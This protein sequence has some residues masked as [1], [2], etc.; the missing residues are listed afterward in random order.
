VTSSITAFGLETKCKEANEHQSQ[1]AK[2]FNGF[3]GKMLCLPR[4][5]NVP[6]SIE[7]MPFLLGLSENNVRGLLFF[8][9]ARNAG[10]VHGFHRNTLPKGGNSTPLFTTF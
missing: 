10:A 8:R 2:A 3:L 4:V 5:G 9:N 1:S 7:L 6:Q